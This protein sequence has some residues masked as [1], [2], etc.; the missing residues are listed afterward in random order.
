MFKEVAQEIREFK[1]LD[2]R[3]MAAKIVAM[4][5]ANQGQNR[6][7]VDARMERE[8]AIGEQMMRDFRALAEAHGVEVPPLHQWGGHGGWLWRNTNT[9]TAISSLLAHKW[10]EYKLL[11]GWKA[12]TFCHLFRWGHD[13]VGAA[14]QLKRHRAT[15]RAD[16]TTGRPSERQRSARRAR[17]EALREVLDVLE[18]G[19]IEQLKE[20][21]REELKSADAA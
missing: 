16:P 10:A 20:S 11:T 7:D 2:V 15:G 14:E 18:A 9:R 21:I 6:K 8:K 5:A 17:V 4:E 12:N 3:A 1:Q 13:P 19:H